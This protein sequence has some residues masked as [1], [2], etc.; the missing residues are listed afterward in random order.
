M[1]V[2]AE[3]GVEAGEDLGFPGYRTLIAL[4]VIRTKEPF[5]LTLYKYGPLL[6]PPSTPYRAR[7]SRSTV[8]RRSGCGGYR[9]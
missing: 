2:D 6:R 8:L 7:T 4:Y 1:T 5:S 3:A 9:Y